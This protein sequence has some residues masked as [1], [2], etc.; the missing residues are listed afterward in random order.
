MVH[1]QPRGI[2]CRIER[3]DEIV[4]L[5]YTQGV[6]KLCITTFGPS[7]AVQFV[8]K[9]RTPRTGRLLRESRHEARPCSMIVPCRDPPS[10]SMAWHARTMIVR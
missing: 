7:H 6:A 1:K 9:H 2:V 4:G 8:W 5:T 10:T 3:G